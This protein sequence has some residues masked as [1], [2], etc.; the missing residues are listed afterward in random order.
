MTLEVVDCG[1]TG[2]LLAGADVSLGQMSIGTTDANGRISPTIDDFTTLPIFKVSKTDYVANNFVFDKAVH[3]NTVQQRCLV[4]P[5]SIPDGHN[6]DIG[7]ESGGQPIGGG[8]PCFI[9][10][11]TTGSPDSAELITLRALRDRISTVS[12]LGSTLIDE[13]YREYAQFSPA[14]ANELTTDDTARTMVLDIVVR[15]LLAWYTLAGDLGLNPD[16]HNH[17]TAAR[18]VT[19][20]CPTQ[21]TESPRV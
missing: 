21:Y 8:G 9:V 16:T 20:A 19:A 7:G 15:P 1:A 18:N 2:T 14:I 17:D 5:G 10:T 13:I 12:T 4:N 3:A 6:P 11:A